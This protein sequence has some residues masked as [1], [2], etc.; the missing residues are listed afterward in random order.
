MMMKD[1][2]PSKWK[3]PRK[4][5][6]KG[7]GAASE[8]PP[9]QS[10]KPKKGSSRPKEDEEGENASGNPGYR[11]EKAES[12]ENWSRPAGLPGGS[13]CPKIGVKGTNLGK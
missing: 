10:R 3:P 1:S 4:A 5:A 13:I 8:G 9:A 12:G 11:K 7:L 6:T 2:R